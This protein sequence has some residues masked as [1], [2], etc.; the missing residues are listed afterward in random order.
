VLGLSKVIGGKGPP[1]MALSSA[2]KPPLFSSAAPTSSTTFIRN[3]KLHR[4]KTQP[5]ITAIK[6]LA[7]EIVAQDKNL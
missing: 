6:Q 4:E 7:R 3:F 1:Q 2:A 5:T